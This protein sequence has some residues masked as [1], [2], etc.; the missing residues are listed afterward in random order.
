MQM[1]KQNPSSVNIEMKEQTIGKTELSQI[2]E[3]EAES[4]K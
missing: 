2:T 1:L 4:K 3:N